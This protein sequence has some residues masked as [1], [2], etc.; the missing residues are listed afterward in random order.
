MKKI[1]QAINLLKHIEGELHFRSPYSKKLLEI[2][3][4]VNWLEKDPSEEK[5]QYTR[6]LLEDLKSELVF[7]GVNK[8]SPLLLEIDIFLGKGTIG[9]D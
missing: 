1:Q 7:S 5:I 2:R 4:L 8:K 6:E 9:E 3:K